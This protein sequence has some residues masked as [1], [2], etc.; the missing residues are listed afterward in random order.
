[1]DLFGAP[2]A[3]EPALGAVRVRH[4][5]PM[6]WREHARTRRRPDAALLAFV[7]SLVAVGTIIGACST[8]STPTEQSV[9]TTEIK[10]DLGVP[11]WM[12]V[13]MDEACQHPADGGGQIS[14]GEAF[15][16][17]VG[18]DDYQVFLLRGLPAGTSL[19]SAVVGG[20]DRC[21]ALQTSADVLPVYRLSTLKPC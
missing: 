3:Q 14:P 13:C 16:Q 9:V 7:A 6:S 10:N 11:V 8:G 2:A 17:A 15:P 19:G 5:E 20:A 12:A 18:P 1:M 4:Y 21:V